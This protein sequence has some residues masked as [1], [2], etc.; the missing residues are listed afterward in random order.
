MLAENGGGA[1]HN[2]ELAEFAY[3]LAD[4]MMEVRDL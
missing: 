4:A 3:K 2:Q 1:L